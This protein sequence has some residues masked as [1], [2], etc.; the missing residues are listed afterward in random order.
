MNKYIFGVVRVVNGFLKSTFVNLTHW[1]SAHIGIPA[2]ISPYTELTF[3]YGSKVQIGRNLKMRSASKIRVRSGATLS[4]GDGFNMSGRNWITARDS[5]V[6]GDNV[7]FGPGT[8][9]YDHDHDF[10]T[11]NGIR[12]GKYLTAPVKIGNNVW[13]GADCIILR[14]TEVGDNC[15]IGAGT[16][17]KGKYESN[18]MI[19]QRRETQVKTRMYQPEE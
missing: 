13:I 16:V 14:G 1:N 9:I 18:L 6:I 11:E 10:S 4:I 12:E 19:Y 3:N 8:I 15:V 17:L 2:F 5:V 7:T